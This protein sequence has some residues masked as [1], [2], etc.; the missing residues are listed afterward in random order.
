MV[1]IRGLFSV[2]PAA[3]WLGGK[4]YSK[5]QY[6]NGVWVPPKKVVLVPYPI[7]LMPFIRFPYKVAGT[8]LRDHKLFYAGCYRYPYHI[9]AFGLFPYPPFISQYYSVKGWIY[10]ARRTWHGI[11]PIAKR[12]NVPSEPGTPYQAGNW[13]AFAEAVKVWQSMEKEVKDLYNKMKYPEKASG[14]NRF[15]SWYLRTHPYMPIYWGTLQRSADDS[16]KI[17]DAAVMKSNPQITYPFQFYNKQAFNFVLH[18]GSGF[19]ENPVEGQ[20][21]YREDEK[22][23]Y[24]FDGSAWGQVG[25]GGSSTDT[26]V[27]TVI[28]AADG[29]GDYTDIQQGINALPSSG[30]LVF[31]KNGTYNISNPI[32]IDKSNVTLQGAGFST[33]IQLN[34]GVNDS[35]I[36]VGDGSNSYSKIVLRD[37]KVDGN[38]ANNSYAS[39]IYVRSNC[40]DV[41]ITGV[42]SYNSNGPGINIDSGS[43]HCNIFGCIIENT[44]SHGI[45]CY[46][47]NYL[48]IQGCKLL[49]TALSYG[50]G[51]EI[52]SA[53][54]FSIIGN[55]LLWT[56]RAV[57][58]SGIMT[59]GYMSN[60]KKGIIANNIIEGCDNGLNL[61]VYMGT[62]ERT[63]V[64]G[65]YIKD[66]Y[67]LGISVLSQ[68]SNIVGNIIESPDGDGIQ[69]STQK[70]I[71]SGNQI[72]DTGKSGIVC[73][74]PDVII[75]GNVLEK[76]QLYGIFF[77]AT[78]NVLIAGN[79]IYDC[80]LE[81]DGLYSAIF[82]YGASGYLCKNNSIYDNVIIGPT[83]G[84]RKGYSIK[85]YGSY[86]DYNMIRGNRCKNAKF[87]EIL[88]SGQ[89]S[90]A[91]DNTITS[92]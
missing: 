46:A 5:R 37:F 33:I 58:S 23:I 29:S 80:S 50:A 11:I 82:C 88:V 10:Q 83:S 89:N 49:N 74:S 14:Y 8:G 32:V 68:N 30:G 27:A 78:E 51:I 2:T 84:N 77:R 19:P 26:R 76:I 52:D 63:I 70:V 35:A 53:I 85:E 64:S 20:L 42:W 56:Q 57:N 41:T 34:N 65:N 62:N 75:Q 12:A 67:N 40:S 22:K 86:V 28:V 17:E 45:N 9:P 72:S 31:I 44:D 39:N 15:I 91:F 43:D 16:S 71:V 3:G 18:K 59:Y 60:A 48:T 36:K 79:R 21:F 1:K 87:V 66:V 69:I 24:R 7:G 55:R 61:A 4:M 54:E 38:K 13:I 25:S 73:Y 81:T 47:A 90:E 92:N 6:R